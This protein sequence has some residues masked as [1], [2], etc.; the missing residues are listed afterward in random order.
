MYASVIIFLP[1]KS[2]L[3]QVQ[4]EWS[5][6]QADVNRGVR[7]RYIIFTKRLPP[8]LILFQA[9]RGF[10]GALVLLTLDKSSQMLPVHTLLLLIITQ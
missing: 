7:D 8:S 1:N 6:C 5:F 2:L 10:S 4:A 9:V 3:N